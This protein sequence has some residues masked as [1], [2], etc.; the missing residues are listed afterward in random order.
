[1]PLLEFNQDINITLGFEILP[2]Y[3]AEKGQFLD[4]M[5]PAE[6]RNFLAAYYDDACH[7][8]SPGL[9]L[10]MV[11]PDSEGMTITNR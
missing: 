7:F 1:V 3:R 8:V 4:M 2:Q 5:P 10:L 9:P 6:I 11:L